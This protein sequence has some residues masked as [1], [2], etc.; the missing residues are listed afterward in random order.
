MNDPIPTYDLQ[1]LCQRSDP[2]GMPAH[3]RMFLLRGYALCR[4]LTLFG[5]SAIPGLEQ[6]VETCV[7]LLLADTEQLRSDPEAAAP[8]ASALLECATASLPAPLLDRCLDTADR[9][10]GHQATLSAFGARLACA[11]DLL[12]P[13]QGYAAAARQ[14]IEAWQPA[15]ELPELWRQAAAMTLYEHATGSQTFVPRA[16]ALWKRGLEAF[17]PGGCTAAQRMELLETAV[18]RQQYETAKALCRP[19]PAPIGEGYR[20][21]SAAADRL[22]EQWRQC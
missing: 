9:L 13:D 12:M 1:R 16:A 2:A 15:A 22:E 19:A 7:R 21:W 6:Q 10:I 14:A 11:C 17:R 3:E 5:H 8:L 20:L 4:E 18:L